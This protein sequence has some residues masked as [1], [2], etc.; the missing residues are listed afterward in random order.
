MAK[1]TPGRVRRGHLVGFGVYKDTYIVEGHPDV[2]IVVC[3]VASD[4]FGGM[5][6]SDLRNEVK[7]LRRLGSFGVP[8]AEVISVGMNGGRPAMLMKRYV[9]GSKDSEKHAHVSVVSKRSISDLYRIAASIER[10]DLYVD[11]I[12]FLYDKDGSVVVADPLAVW[13]YSERKRFDNELFLE[14]RTEVA[15]QISEEIGWCRAALKMKSGGRKIKN[16]AN[17]TTFHR[18]KEM[19]KPRIRACISIEAA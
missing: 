5:D 13:K 4:G 8:V 18:S 19:M 2:V 11:D 16:I 17:S 12:Q 15:E 1:L 9:G 7:M 10:H 14:E 6:I 3:R